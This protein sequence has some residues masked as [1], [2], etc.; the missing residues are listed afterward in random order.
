MEIYKSVKL[1]D[2]KEWYEANIQY[3]DPSNIETFTE[4]MQDYQKYKENEGKEE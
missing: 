4:M 3:Y 1:E 2:F